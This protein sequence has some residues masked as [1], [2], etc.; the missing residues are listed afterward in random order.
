MQSRK[1]RKVVTVFDDMIADAIGNKK[2]NPIVTGLFTRARKINIL[3]T[4]ITQIHFNVPKEARQN[5]KYFFIMK[6]QNK[7]E[8]QQITLNHSSD[9]DFKNFRKIYKKRAK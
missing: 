2:L 3:I 5:T 1:K 6:I 8:L 9:I 7:R 4:F